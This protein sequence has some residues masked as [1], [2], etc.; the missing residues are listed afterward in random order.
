MKR[1]RVFVQPF[2]VEADSITAARQAAEERLGPLATSP[3]VERIE[4]RIE[5]SSQEEGAEGAMA[6]RKLCANCLE[7]INE[8][9]GAFTCHTCGGDLCERCARTCYDCEES[10]CD[11]CWPLHSASEA[12]YQEEEEET[13][14]RCGAVLD[15][16]GDGY[17]GL[18]ADC[19]DL[20][21]DKDEDEEEEEE[22]ADDSFDDERAMRDLRGVLAHQATVCRVCHADLSRESHLPWCENVLDGE[23]DEH[24]GEA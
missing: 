12:S 1:Y 6:M 16:A 17:D 18:C 23:Y 24:G 21:E 3:V 8:Y 19:A 22:E 10:F 2:E 15:Q 9:E 4:E 5:P 14:R 13:C 11:S 7:D 20:A